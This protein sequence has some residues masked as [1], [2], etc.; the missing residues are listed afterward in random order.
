MPFKDP[1]TAL[2]ASAIEGQIQGDQI[3]ADAI[4]GKTITGA[5]IRTGPTGTRRVELTPDGRVRFHT[6]HPAQT[7]AGEIRTSLTSDLPGWAEGHI[8]I[9]PP[10]HGG[11]APPE[12]DLF[13]DMEGGQN[14]TLGPLAVAIYREGTARIPVVNVAGYLGVEGDADVAKNLRAGNIRA[15]RVNITPTAANTPTSIT[16]TG[17]GMPP[18]G[19]PRAVATPATTL[20]GTAVTGVGCSTVTRDS[21]TIWLTRT[22]T[23]ATGID[24]IVIGE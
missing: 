21:V 4:D 18:G 8:V 22:N 2:P 1:T 13:L 6:G 24:Y 15:G 14:W 7:G 23:T 16:V 3:S 19:P 20:P 9:R 11:Y 10:V 17:L 12:L 5:L